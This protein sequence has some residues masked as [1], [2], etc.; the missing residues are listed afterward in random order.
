LIPFDILKPLIK[1][2]AE[3][4]IKLG[5]FESQTGPARR[6]DITVMKQ[7]LKMLDDKDFRELYKKISNMINKKYST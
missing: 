4:V 6:S 5:P 2:T 3:K 7:H 1:E